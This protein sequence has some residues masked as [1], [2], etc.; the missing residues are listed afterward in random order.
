M[1]KVD[2]LQDTDKLSIL[3]TAEYAL[4]FRIVFKLEENIPFMNCKD[5]ILP[6]FTT[7]HIRFLDVTSSDIIP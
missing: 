1:A 5:M 2:L 4:K 6:R 3:K 7:N